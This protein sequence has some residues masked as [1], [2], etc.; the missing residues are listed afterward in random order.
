MDE[1]TAKL[2][3]NAATELA[4]EGHYGGEVFSLVAVAEIIHDKTG[5]T[6]EP[7]LEKMRLAV[8]LA[9]QSGLEIQLAAHQAATGGE[10]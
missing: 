9:E 7:L 5:L 8:K 3:V 10:A 2:C 1:K 4:N 6:G